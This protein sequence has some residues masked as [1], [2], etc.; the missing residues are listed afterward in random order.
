M[1]I[2]FFWYVTPC[3]LVYRY[4]HLRG[5]CTLRL[6]GRRTNTQKFARCYVS[7]EWTRHIVF[8]VILT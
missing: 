6:Q 5:A 1:N 4:E 3:R 8:C 7:E 2:S